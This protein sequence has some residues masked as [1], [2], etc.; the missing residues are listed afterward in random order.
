MPRK[1]RRE[2]TPESADEHEN[3]NQDKKEDKNEGTNGSDDPDLPPSEINPYT[4]LSLARTATPDQIRT[5]YRQAALK[6]HPD[7]APLSS[8]HTAHTRFQ[9]IAFAYAILSDEKR[10]ARYDRTGNTAESL[11]DD[12]DDFDWLDFFR[13]QTQAVVSG[14]L[15]EEVKREYQGSDAER[16]DVLTAYVDCEGDM[17]GVYE[18]IMCSSVLDDDERFRGWIDEAV[19][20]GRVETFERYMRETKA[21]K[22]KRVREARGEEAEAM[23]LAD[24][25]GVKGK[26]FGTTNRDGE[27]D[28]LKA[29]IQARQEDRASGFLDKLEQKYGGGDG[30]KKTKRKV[31]EPPEESFRQNARKSRKRT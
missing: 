3:E 8:K 5:A 9:E 17:D 6:H 2:P 16:E 22:R 27:E 14:A 18:R 19:A 28:A 24:E 12:D 11:A 29:M 26:L 23:A 13:E 10:R 30:D 4:V 7:K 1:P 21:S 31:D 25:L 20:E 15:I